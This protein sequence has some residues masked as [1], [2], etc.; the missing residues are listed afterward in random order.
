[1][2]GVI[3]RTIEAPALDVPRTGETRIAELDGLR[4]IAVLMVIL[5]HFVVPAGETSNRV[6]NTF[7]NTF[8]IGWAGVDLFFV[9]SGFLIG[10]IL[11]D[12]KESKS[13]FKTFYLRRVYRIFPLYYLWVAIYFLIAAA[14][15]AHLAGQLA[16]FPGRWIYIPVYA[17]YLQNT[18]KLNATMAS[19]WLAHLWSLAVEEQFY[20][21]TPCL[22]RF[23]SR[24]KLLL[25]LLS[26]MVLAPLTRVLLVLY[27]PS[28]TFAPYR[29]TVCRAD[30]LA[31]GVLIAMVWRD[32]TSLQWILAHRQA[33]NAV[34]GS[35]FLGVIYLAIFHPTQYGALS[36]LGYSCI[37]LFFANLLLWT[38]LTLEGRW[39]AF[40]RRPFLMALGGVSYCMYVIHLAVNFLCH[41]VLAG[42]VQ[43]I[44]TWPAFAATIAAG[45]ITWSIAKFSW[46]FFESP[47]LRRGHA[48]RY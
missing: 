45:G 35:L 11:L 42:S 37:D 43:G 3:S 17:F 25:L 31:A 6:A 23:L 5:F 29:M 4:G 1:M 47:M 13:Y 15:S 10:G 20:L 32:S 26:T 46:R 9:L 34:F 36:V 14:S 7:Y 28:H 19:P 22:I 24:G 2:D 16:V 38:L 27:F 39:A 30:A 12:A 33:M 8:R 41:A 21:V 44:S 48:F 40:C 18:W